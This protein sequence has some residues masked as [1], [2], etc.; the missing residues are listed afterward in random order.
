EPLLNERLTTAFPPP[1]DVDVVEMTP[2]VFVSDMLVD[3][4]LEGTEDEDDEVGIDGLF[5][6]TPYMT[7]VSL[8]WLPA[9]ELFRR[10][11]PLFMW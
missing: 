10:Q 11:V 7:L 8:V 5:A 6:L 2:K 1:A 4:S 3:M 9:I